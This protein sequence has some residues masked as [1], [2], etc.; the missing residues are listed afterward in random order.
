[1]KI[2]PCPTCGSS[3]LYESAPISAGG[4]YAPNYLPDLGGFWSS[5]RFR[6][7]M[8]GS[9]GLTRFFASPEARQKVAESNRWTRVR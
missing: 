4:G 1:M 9:C 2:A 8:C 5:A 3:E 6:L 7:V